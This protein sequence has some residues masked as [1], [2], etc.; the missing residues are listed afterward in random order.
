MRTTVD[1]PDP[2]FKQLKAVAALRGTTLK[3]LL[4]CAVERELR[5]AK[6][7]NKT[8]KFPLVPSKEPGTLTLTNA[9]IDEILFS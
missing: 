4:I 6:R 1:L 2:V 9:E 7:P 5:S 3:Q 8:A